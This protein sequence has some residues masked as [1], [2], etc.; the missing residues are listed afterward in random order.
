[1]SCPIELEIKS[2]VIEV[3]V[4]APVAEVEVISA[5]IAVEI[6]PPIAQVEVIPAITEIEVVPYAI[7]V[8][9]QPVLAN[10]TNIVA[11]ASGYYN[12]R[13][14]NFS[15]DLVFVDTDAPIQYLY[16]DANGLFVDLPNPISSSG[17][18]FKIFNWGTNKFQLREFGLVVFE[19]KPNRVLWL[20]S[21]GIQWNGHTD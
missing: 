1:M 20:H 2:V 5:P 14:L 12:W 11:G 17:R 10:V 16:A 19:L 21:D 15:T 3:E 9:I 8:E 18:W 4:I 7:T 13:S 6:V